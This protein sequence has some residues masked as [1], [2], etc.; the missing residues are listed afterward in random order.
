MRYVGY[1]LRH[2]FQCTD[3]HKHSAIGKYLYNIHNQMDKGLHDQFTILKKCQG[4]LDCLIHEMLFIIEKKP[5]LKPNLTLSKQHYLPDKYHLLHFILYFSL[6][7][8]CN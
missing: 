7:I 5:R 3:E 6:L 2:L 1:T 8:T 4:K